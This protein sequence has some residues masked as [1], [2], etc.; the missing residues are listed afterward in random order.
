MSQ[1]VSSPGFQSANPTQQEKLLVGAKNE[2][3]RQ[4]KVTFALQAAKTAVDDNALVRAATIGERASVSTGQKMDFVTQLSQANTLNPTVQAAID[5]MRTQTDPLKPKYE[6]SVA[7]LQK[8]SALVSQYLAAPAYRVGTTQD[9]TDAAKQGAALHATYQSLLAEAVQKST[10]TRK[11]PVTALPDYQHYIKD[12]ATA[13]TSTGRPVSAF[14][15]KTGTI[16]TKLVSPQRLAI[17][18]DPLF[19]HFSAVASQRDP[20]SVKGTTTP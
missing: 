5:D 16:D 10:A 1:V 14:I 11:V 3:D 2:A 18:K 17:T 15:T 7:E 4:A 20:Y 9:W 13:R 12:W 8:G 19:T 6:L